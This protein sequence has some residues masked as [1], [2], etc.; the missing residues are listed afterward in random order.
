MRLEG[1]VCCVN[2]ADY[3]AD[4]LPLNLRHFDRLVVVTAPEDVETQRLCRYYDV[5]HLQTDVF[6]SRWAEFHKACGINKGLQ[7][8]RQDD[9]VLHMDADIVL[10]PRTRELI[11]RANLDK[12]KLYGCD[13]FNVPGYDAWRQHQAMPALQQDNYHVNLD[14]FP[15][16]PRFSGER[17]GGYAPPGFLQLWSGT[18]GRNLR[19]PEE[20][21][22]ASRTDVLFTANWFRSG[23]EMLPEFV[24]Y[25]L[26]AAQET[27]GIDWGGRVSRRWGP[28]PNYDHHHPFHHRDPPHHHEHHHPDGRWH[29]HYHH[30]CPPP[31]P[32]GEGPEQEQS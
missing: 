18:T 1:V 22:D 17:M 12:G 20:H 29:H 23:R 28:Q 32:Y 30:P 9:W 14:V 2:M 4:T 27:Q 5:P 6:R 25:H 19:Y 31:W 26:A 13:R 11:E 21:S 15:L 10:P 24:A 16:A 8:L 7:A 3:L